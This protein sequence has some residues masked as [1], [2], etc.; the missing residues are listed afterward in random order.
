MPI[1][2]HHKLI[3][4]A[5]VHQWI[6]RGDTF[7]CRYDLVGL[8]KGHVSPAY[9]CIYLLDGKEHI[10]VATNAR[11]DGKVEEREVR[12]WPGVVRFHAEHGDS[13]KLVY[14]PLTHCITTWRPVD[15]KH[16]ELSTV[17]KLLDDS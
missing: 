4:V 13:T 8:G 3:T 2:R 7:Q 17:G 11:P 15:D 1:E 16:L 9:N 10:L 6:D 14:D 5:G 12:F